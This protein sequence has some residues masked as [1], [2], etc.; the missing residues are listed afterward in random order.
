MINYINDILLNNNVVKKFNNKFLTKKIYKNKIR[1]FRKKLKTTSYHYQNNASFNEFSI[2]PLVGLGKKNI[3]NQTIEHLIASTKHEI[4][5]CTP[6]FNF[7]KYLIHNLTYLLHSG[8][9]VK[10]IV[11]DKISNDFYNPNQEYKPFKLISALPYL[12]EVNL[13]YF[14]KKFQSYI[15][16]NQLTILIWK[17]NDNGYHVK[18]I[19]VDNEWQLLT[20]SNL[21]PRSMRFDLE[22]ALLIHD[23]FHELI[24]EK[25]KEL[26]NIQFFSNRI[27][28]YT[29]IQR[30][31]DYPIKIKQLIRRLRKIRFDKLI[32]HIL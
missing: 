23:P 32:N 30:I 13:R 7:P 5:L 14:S 19:W 29:N 15:N 31:S 3:L 11:G 17:N 6:Y 16:N 10:I 9:Q 27:D 20:G 12:Y 22:N 1:L 28:H 25:Q 4:I 21:N 24:H 2:T 8:K 18:G 26:K